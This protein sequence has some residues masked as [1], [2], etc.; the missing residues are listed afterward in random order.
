MQQRGQLLWLCCTLFTLL[1]L[2]QKSLP[3]PAPP[4]VLQEIEELDP[5][6]H[7]MQMEVKRIEWDMWSIQVG[8]VKRWP[9]RAGAGLG[10][11]QGSRVVEALLAA[12]QSGM[13]CCSAVAVALP[14]MCEHSGG[15]P[16]P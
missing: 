7:E 12:G 10:I 2:V 11:T 5:R 16:C 9:R 4:A 1:A 14:R 8:A 15:S 13:D 3:P 6:I